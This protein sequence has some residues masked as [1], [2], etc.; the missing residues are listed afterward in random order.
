MTSMPKSDDRLLA[1]FRRSGKRRSSY[2]AAQSDRA[3]AAMQR[4][5][6]Q[7]S[8]GC[9]FAGQGCITPRGEVG[10]CDGHLKCIVDPFPGGFRI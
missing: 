7:R 10:I 4:V 2:R 9:S 1:S 5:M 6:L 3:T 8:H